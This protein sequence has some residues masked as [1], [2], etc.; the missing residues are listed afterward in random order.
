[1]ERIKFG[2]LGAGGF[3]REV[4]PFAKGSVAK[5]LLVPGN[6]IDVYFVETW[7]PKEPAVN[8]YSV[9]SLDE[10][11]ELNGKKYFN[12]AVGSGRDR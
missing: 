12:V 5:T 3:A 2:L 11:I 4:M 9:L 10:F 1:M 7:H 6:N 8:G